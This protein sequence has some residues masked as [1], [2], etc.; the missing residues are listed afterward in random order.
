MTMYPYDLKILTK[1]DLVTLATHK[2]LATATNGVLKDLLEVVTLTPEVEKKL[3]RKVFDTL[4]NVLYKSLEGSATEHELKQAERHFQITLFEA[5][6]DRHLD[7]K[8]T[9]K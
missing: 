4:D 1:E 6:L 7:E 3:K 5:D 9:E 8:L 2:K